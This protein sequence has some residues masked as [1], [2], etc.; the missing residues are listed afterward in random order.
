MFYKYRLYSDNHIQLTVSIVVVYCSSSC[1]FLVFFVCPAPTLKVKI[2]DNGTF[3]EKD[4][5]A[6]AT[7]D[8]VEFQCDA[9]GADAN[10]TERYKWF[11]NDQVLID[12]TRCTMLHDKC[13]INEF[14]EDN[15]AGVYHCEFKQD[16][17]T[18]AA[19]QKKTTLG[20]SKLF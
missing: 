3:V 6:A 17:G 13:S 11:F 15:H 8:A 20:L 14:K 12:D 19:S 10:S 7:D 16:G 2:G 5:A 1:S 9:S 18:Y 4:V